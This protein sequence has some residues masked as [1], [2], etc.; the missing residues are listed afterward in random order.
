MGGGVLKWT[1]PRTHRQIL[2]A[3]RAKIMCLFTFKHIVPRLIEQDD[4][5]GR[6]NS[7]SSVLGVGE[8]L[9]HSYFFLTLLKQISTK[10]C[11]E[12]AHVVSVRTS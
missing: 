1:L 3:Q 8:L 2:G 12:S 4:V 9:K 5:V 11:H 7:L 6:W 10:F